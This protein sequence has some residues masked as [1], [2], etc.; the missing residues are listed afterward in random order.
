MTFVS[1]RSSRISRRSAM[2]V[3]SAP[4]GG[5]TIAIWDHLDDY[6][7]EPIDGDNHRAHTLA[8]AAVDYD[9]V[10]GQGWPTIPSGGGSSIFLN[11]LSANPN[12]G[13]NWTRTGASGDNLGSYNA[14]PLV[15]TAIDHPGGDVGSPGYAP[16]ATASGLLGDYNGNFVVDAADYTVW[17]DRLS[18]GGSLLNDASPGSVSVEDY[19]YW[20][21]HFGATALGGGGIAVVPEPTALGLWL[22]AA[23]AT[24]L[25]RRNI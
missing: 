4:M 6:D 14:S 12:Q 2:D 21:S 15:Q 3:T 17:R 25:P 11:D 20:K 16:G 10:A 5:D 18:G 19:N 8:V 23:L 13:A 9:T 24:S 22:I 7:N 1:G